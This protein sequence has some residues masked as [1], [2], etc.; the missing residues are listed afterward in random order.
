MSNALGE[1]FDEA[2][3]YGE[4]RLSSHDDGTFYAVIDFKCIP[5]VT[6]KADS[7]WG[8]KTPVEALVK[9]IDKAKEVTKSID[10][11]TNKWQIPYNQK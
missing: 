8:R 9:V 7:G 5:G 10:M 4:V 1:L 11:S 2:L 6:L 3:L